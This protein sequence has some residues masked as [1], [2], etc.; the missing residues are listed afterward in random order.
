[1]SRG[2][3]QA[4]S[5]LLAALIV[6]GVTLASTGAPAAQAQGSPQIDLRVLVIGLSNSDPVTQAWE[7]QLTAEGVPYDLV[8]PNGSSLTLPNLVDPNNA[9]RGL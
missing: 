4:V 1:M 2:F 8:L 5:G 3:R 9:N 6:A 7:S